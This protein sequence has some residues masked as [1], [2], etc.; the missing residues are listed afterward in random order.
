MKMEDFSSCCAGTTFAN[1]MA[2]ASPFSS[3]EHEIT[4]ARDIWYRKLNVR[5]WL[6]AIS[7]RSCSNEYL[8]TAN[9][10]TVQEL[11]EWRLRYE[12]KFGYVFV[13]FVAGRTFEDILAELKIRFNN[14][15]GVELEIVST[16]ELKY[17]ERAIRELLSKKSIQTTDEGDVSAEYS[18]KIVADTLDGADT[19]SED[20]LDAISSGGYDISRDVELNKVPEDNE[21]LNTQHREDAVRA[22]KRGFDLNKLPWFGDDLSDP[23]SRHCSEFLT[24]YF[25]PGQ[26]DV[27]EK[28]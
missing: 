11:H 5:S 2:M 4:V 28:L 10:A 22:A 27:D 20:D 1:E 18:G 26:Y 17:I 21:T 13:T 15:H 14:S 16:E 8:E 3:L 24:E 7:G 25:W 19:N 9:E 12:E 6:E 23:L